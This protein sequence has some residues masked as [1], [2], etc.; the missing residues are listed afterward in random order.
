MLASVGVN[1]ESLVRL[2]RA[3]TFKDFEP[4]KMLVLVQLIV[5]SNNCSARKSR[6]QNF[7]YLLSLT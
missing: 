4:A 7:S 1:P 5:K 3:F 2:C 6:V